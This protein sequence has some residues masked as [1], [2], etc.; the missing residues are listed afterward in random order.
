MRSPADMTTIQ[1]DI[2]NACNK[3]CSNCTRFCG[4][5]RKAFFMDIDTFKKA[6]DSLDGFEGVV[7][8]MGGEPTLHPRFDEIVECVKEKFGGRE[9]DNRMVYPQKEFIKEIRRHE[10]ESRQLREGEG[11]RNFRM[12][13][14]GLWSNMGESYRKKYEIINEVFDVQF[15]NDHINPS[16][17]QP[18]LISRK[19]LDIPD[20][21]WIKLRDK[22]WVQNEWSATITPKGCFF[23][24][25]AGALDMLFDGPGG[26]PIEGEWW[27]RRPDEFGEQL[28]WCEICGF[29]LNTFMRDAE[30]ETD[31]VSISLYHMLEK[32]DSPRLKRDKTNIIKVRDGVI[33]DESK[34]NYHAFAPSQPYIEHY[35]DR[36]NES[37]SALFINEYLLREIGEGDSFGLQLRKAI[38]DTKDWILIRNCATTSVDEISKLTKKYIFNPGTLHLGEDYIFFSKNAISLKNINDDTLIEMKSARDLIDKWN[39]HK[40]VK[41]SDIEMNLKWQRKSIVA[42]KRY[43]IWGAGFSGGFI[44]D[45]INGSNGEYVFAIDSNPDK[46]GSDYWGKVTHTPD[47]LID[48]S[49]EYDYLLIAHYTRFDEIYSQ[50]I[51]M[52]IPKDRIIMPYEL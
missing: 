19:D 41:I 23:C 21:A 50:A 7:G 30:E 43:A 48:N 31:D 35:E 2:T 20:D 10:F 52:G 12:C 40:V 49:D 3:A 45:M 18:G 37:N 8:I 51:K 25:I 27:K 4:N 34:T 1:I 47:Y 36:F 5:H 32:I 38:A 14:P 6:L 42:G 24:E 26:W 15:L 17:H 16:Y 9:A 13:G 29:A 28:K 44:V 39:F 46:S 11:S 33:A 22:C